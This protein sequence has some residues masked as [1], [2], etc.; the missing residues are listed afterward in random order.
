MSRSYKKTPVSAHT[1][2]ESD[3]KY[4]VQEHQR[5]RSNVRTALNSCKDYEELILQDS[6]KFGDEWSAP[7]DGKQW[8]K[9]Y[10]KKD[11]CK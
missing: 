4:K 6:K 7:K 9:K 8:M 5:E 3:K 2:A 1:I 10:T 11:M